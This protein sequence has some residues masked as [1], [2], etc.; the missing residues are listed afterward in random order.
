MFKKLFGQGSGQGGGGGPANSANSTG[1]TVDA[2]QK[3]GEVCNP[4]LDRLFGGASPAVGTMLLLEEW[5]SVTS[6]AQ[7]SHRLRSCS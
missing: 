2:I 7:R 5:H 4:P 1:R 3:L 6:V